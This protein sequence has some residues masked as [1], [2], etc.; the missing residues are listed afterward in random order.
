ME[1]NNL[2][3]GFGFMLAIYIGVNLWLNDGTEKYLSNTIDLQIGIDETSEQYKLDAAVDQQEAADTGTLTTT[4][5][6]DEWYTSVSIWLKNVITVPK[7]SASIG[8]TAGKFLGIVQI[9][10][11]MEEIIRT[12]IIYTFV[13]AIFAAFL[14]WKP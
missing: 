1:L 3:L 2:L 11:E 14:R 13:L 4:S 9:P 5:S 8:D 10:Q 6:G 12:I 7:W